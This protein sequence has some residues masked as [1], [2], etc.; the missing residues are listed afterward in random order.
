[1][2]TFSKSNLK[3]TGFTGVEVF[4]EKMEDVFKATTAKESFLYITITDPIRMWIVYIYWNSAITLYKLYDH[5]SG[6]NTL[7]AENLFFPSNFTDV[8]LPEANVTATYFDLTPLNIIKVLL[9]Q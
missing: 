1:M 9:F 8:D 6:N 4:N 5:D 7:L 2:N 3:S